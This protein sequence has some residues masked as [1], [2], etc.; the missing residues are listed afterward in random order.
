MPNTIPLLDWLEAMES[1]YLSTFIPNGGASV[2]FAVTSD[3]LKADLY[4]ALL[5]WCEKSGMLLVSLDAVSR[6]AHMPQDLFHGL[7][8]VRGL[9]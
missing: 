1:E 5:E 4:A 8:C 9:A 2:K 3:S 6:R 7:A